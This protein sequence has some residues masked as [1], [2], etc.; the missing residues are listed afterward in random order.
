MPMVE[1]MGT[2]GLGGISSPVLKGVEQMNVTGEDLGQRGGFN[3][4]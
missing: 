3:W 4:W 2:L 1:T